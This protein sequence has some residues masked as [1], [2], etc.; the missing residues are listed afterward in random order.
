MFPSPGVLNTLV[1]DDGDIRFAAA[2]APGGNCQTLE[3]GGAPR[4]TQRLQF[5]LG[6]GVGFTHYEPQGGVPPGSPPQHKYSYVFHGANQRFAVRYLESITSDN[7][8]MFRIQVAEVGTQT[9]VGEGSPP[10]DTGAEI[11]AYP[12]PF[13]PTVRIE[14][15][16]TAA[17]HE[18]IAIVDVSG[19]RLRLLQGGRIEPGRR[20]FV[21]DGRCENGRPAASGVYWVTLAD[22]AAA[23]RKRIVLIR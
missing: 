7:Y 11:T 22:G 15:R 18:A 14:C 23:P 2:L 21:W 19:R 5:D 10:P 17:A 1:S 8:G 16:G 12:N 13:N 4:H 3:T 20:V 9:G 6:A